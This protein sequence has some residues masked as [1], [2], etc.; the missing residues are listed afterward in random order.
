VEKR[1]TEENV[2]RRKREGER[3][4]IEV[5]ER[6]MRTHK[7]GFEKSALMSRIVSNI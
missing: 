5:R 2:V 1:K 4:V 3:K 7:I 6:K